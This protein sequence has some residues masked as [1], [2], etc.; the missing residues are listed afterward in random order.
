MIPLKS[1]PC[2]SEIT[3][4][5]GGS[6]DPPHIGHRLAVHGL[7]RVPGVKRVIVIPA[8]SPPHKPTTA[9]AEQRAEMVKLNFNPD[10][11]PLDIEIDSRELI[12]AAKNPRTPSY[13]FDTLM[14][15]QSLSPKL[16]FV[17]GSDQLEQL[18]TW[19]RFPDLLSLCHWIVLERKSAAPGEGLQ[20]LS[21]WEASGL[22]EKTRQDRLWQST[23]NR[24]FFLHRVPTEARSISSTEIRH[25]IA[26]TGIP[27][28][29]SLFPDVLSY[30]KVHRLY[31]IQN[32]S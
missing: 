24:N 6:F 19:H 16:A 8:A 23:Q 5:F 7:F 4:I 11:T 10:E 27:P 30:L 15:L 20:T 2:W 32:R 28:E 21:Q 1:P 13:S 29:N 31:G 3:A 26:R 9:S 22:I 18:S 17:I 25:S 12:R 14:E